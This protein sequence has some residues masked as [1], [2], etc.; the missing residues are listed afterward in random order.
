MQPETRYARSGDVSI[1]YQVVGDGPFDVVFVPPTVSHVELG[2]DVRGMRLLRERISSFARLIHFDKRGTGM[3]DRVAGAPTL[4][5]RM[6]D[7]RAVMDAAGSERAAM[8]GWSEG[9]AMCALFAATYPE[10]AWALVLYGGAARE[11]RA[12]DYPGGRRRRR[13]CG[14]SRSNGLRLS[15]P[16][17]PSYSHAR[18]CRVQA[19]RRWRSLLA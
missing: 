19:P 6:D 1:A 15:V 13:H 16:N 14:R 4:E 2:W 12:P 3:S 10:R 7:V 5:T 18:E 17:S 11:L 8:I 9:V